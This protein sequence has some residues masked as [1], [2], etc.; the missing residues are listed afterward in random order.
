MEERTSS[1]YQMNEL[2]HSLPVAETAAGSSVICKT[3]GQLPDT[4][5]AAVKRYAQKST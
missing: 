5:G 4:M 1:V 3:L 2:L